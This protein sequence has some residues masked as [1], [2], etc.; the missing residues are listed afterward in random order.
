MPSV[1]AGLFGPET[2][3]SRFQVAIVTHDHIKQHDPG[4]FTLDS[5]GNAGKKSPAM[6]A[7]PFHASNIPQE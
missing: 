5:I 1:S 3:L 4:F 6:I 2:E 7:H